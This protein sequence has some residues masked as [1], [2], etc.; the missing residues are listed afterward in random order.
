MIHFF[1]QKPFLCD[2]IPS[3]HIDIHSHLLPGIDD[4]STSVEESISLINQMSAIGFKNIITTPHLITNVWN[5]TEESV[6]AKHSEVIVSIRD[7]CE[8]ATFDVGIEYMMDDIFMKRVQTEKLLTLKDNYILVEVSYLNPPIQLYEII[9]EIQLAGYKPILAH[10]ERYLFY[11]KSF[12]EYRK[13]K[14][15]G[16]L[17]QLNLL[18]TVGYYGKNIELATERLLS[19]NYYDFVGSDIHHQKHINA[20][21]NKVNLKSLPQLE[22]AI[23]NNLFFLE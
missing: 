2:L 1:K 5:N 16:C 11:H 22:K 23:N 6:T 7:N 17:F 18:S 20:F 19:E 21:S 12:K 3:N 9:F 10:P 14:N 13:L 15:A 8:V 4:G